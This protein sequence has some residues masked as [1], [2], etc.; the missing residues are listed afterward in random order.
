MQADRQFVYVL[1]CDGFVKIGI[2]KS[3]PKRMAGIQTGS[4]HDVEFLGMFP[5]ISP[6]EDEANLHRHY[7]EFRKRGEWFK[8]PQDKLDKLLRQACYHFRDFED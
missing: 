6:A 7:S 8:L 1:E 4:P 5:T 2:A 3:V